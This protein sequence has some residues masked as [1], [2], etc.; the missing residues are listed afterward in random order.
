MLD[1]IILFFEFI[2]IIITMFSMALISDKFLICN[3][4]NNYLS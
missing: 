1:N 2:G 4:N 3:L